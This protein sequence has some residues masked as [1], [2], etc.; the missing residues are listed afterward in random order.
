[1]IA[2]AVPKKNHGDEVI[3]GLIGEARDTLRRMAGE[4]ARNIEY[5][6]R[7]KEKMARLGGPRG[8]D[9]ECLHIHVWIRYD[10]MLNHATSVLKKRYDHDMLDRAVKRIDGKVLH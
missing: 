4:T 2:I 3:H 5:R 8:T 10:G 6:H 7:V 9:I 1:M